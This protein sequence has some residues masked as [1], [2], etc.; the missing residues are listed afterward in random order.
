MALTDTDWI[1]LTLGVTS[2]VSAF[3]LGLRQQGEKRDATDK[4]LSDAFDR[5]DANYRSEIEWLRKQL[6]EQ[7]RPPHDGT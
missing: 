6:R 2:T 7:E 3:I 1:T 4:L 5:A